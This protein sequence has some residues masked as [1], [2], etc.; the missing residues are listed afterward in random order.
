M[1][2]SGDSQT[3]GKQLG[4]SCPKPKRKR[5]RDLLALY[6]NTPCLICRVTEGV[7]GHHIKSKGSGGP[8][9]L[10]NLMPLC[11]IHHDLIHKMHLKLF[12]KKFLK[13]QLWVEFWGW[14]YEYEKWFTP[15]GE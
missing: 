14:T 8:D 3:A 12:A 2:D 11:A 4:T 7:C 10:W 5:D 1:A 15:E 13:A 9:E 6:R